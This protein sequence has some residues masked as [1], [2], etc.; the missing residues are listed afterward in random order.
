MKISLISSSLRY[1]S[2]F[3][4]L[5]AGRRAPFVLFVDYVPTEL[6]KYVVDKEPHYTH[7]SKTVSIKRIEFLIHN[8]FVM[9]GGCAFQQTVDIPMD[10]N[11]SFLLVASYRDFNRR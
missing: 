10:T 9:I 11:S 6:D 2:Q 3:G 1:P 7:D 5:I 8:I 4:I